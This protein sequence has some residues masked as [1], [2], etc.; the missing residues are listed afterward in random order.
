MSCCRSSCVCPLVQ[1]V[2]NTQI[3]HAKKRVDSNVHFSPQLL[4]GQFARDWGTTE[5][6]ES[7]FSEEGEAEEGAEG[8]MEAHE[9][10]EDL[11]L[12]D[13]YCVACNKTF[14]TEKA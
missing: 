7:D 10:G 5:S 3:R 8:T 11:L 2:L 6:E 14:K 12:D 1:Y 9:A 13:L 4:E